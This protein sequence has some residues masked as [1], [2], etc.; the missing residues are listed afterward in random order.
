MLLHAQA[1][2][3]PLARTLRA[4]QPFDAISSDEYGW[5]TNLNDSGRIRQGADLVHRSRSVARRA[6]TRGQRNDG[7]VASRQPF[8]GASATPSH[9][10]IRAIAIIPSP[11]GGGGPF[12]TAFTG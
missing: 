4:G 6:A 11:A 1:G 10:P 7:I 3:L 2:D 5:Q 9:T 8:R 12:S